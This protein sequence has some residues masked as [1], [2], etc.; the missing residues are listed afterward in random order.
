MIHISTKGYNNHVTN[1][2]SITLFGENNTNKR[3]VKTHK[4]MHEK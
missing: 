1:K 3:S 4:F 2:N